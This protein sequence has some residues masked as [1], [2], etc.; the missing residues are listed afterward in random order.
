MVECYIGIDLGTTNSAI[1][2]GHTDSGRIKPEI[3]EIS[4]Q[5]DEIGQM[6]EEILLPS[7]AYFPRPNSSIVG[8]H[9]KSM[10]QVEPGSVAKSMKCYMDPGSKV[11]KG[12]SGV[13]LDSY[14]DCSRNSQI[15]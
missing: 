3:I 1:A 8:N 13:T 14:S 12:P 6:R 5:V 2:W 9:A 10:I 7:C 15:S 11:F 4:R